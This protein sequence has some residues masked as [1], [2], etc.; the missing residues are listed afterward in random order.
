MAKSNQAAEQ[1]QKAAPHGV[2]PAAEPANADLPQTTGV[3]RIPWTWRVV[4]MVFIVCFSI[5]V[6]YEASVLVGKLFK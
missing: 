5:M 4:F 1:I 6:L 2:P 3:Q